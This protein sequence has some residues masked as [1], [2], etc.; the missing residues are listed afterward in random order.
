MQGAFIRTIFTEKY[1][2]T[3]ITESMKKR[4]EKGIWQRRYYEHI[5]R[6]ENDLWK[7][8]DYIHFNS[9]K[10][11]NIAPKDWENSSFKKFVKNNFYDENWCN[12][13]DINKILEMNLE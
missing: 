3:D 12:Y 9:I 13:N 4:N 11:Y 10:H 5:I 1:Y 7:H 2:S 6:N 8:I